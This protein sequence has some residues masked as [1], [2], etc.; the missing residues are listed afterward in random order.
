MAPSDD[1]PSPAL[2][3]ESTPDGPVAVLPDTGGP[4]VAVLAVFMAVVAGVSLAVRRIR[5]RR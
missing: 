1:Y 5:E 3:T 2:P 4:P